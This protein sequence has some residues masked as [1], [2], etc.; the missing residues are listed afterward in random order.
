MFL[1]FFRCAHQAGAT[2]ARAVM[3]SSRVDAYAYL[4]PDHSDLAFEWKGA[5]ALKQLN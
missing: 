1:F 3:L 5:I 2:C 4:T